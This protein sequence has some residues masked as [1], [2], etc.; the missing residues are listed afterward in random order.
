[1]KRILYIEDERV[2]ARTVQAQ[3][4][5]RGYQVDLVS[6]AEEG[7]EKLKQ[8]QYDL[9]LAD[10]NLPGMN[11]IELLQE[12]ALRNYSLP[13]IILTA[14]GDEKVAAEALKWGAADYV[15][16]EPTFLDHLPHTVEMTLSEHLALRQKEETEAALQQ[17]EA[18]YRALIEALP[19]I[20]LQVDL[21][22][23]I[24]Y[25]RTPEADRHL[26]KEAPAGVMFREC[27]SSDI[28]KQIEANFREALQYGR[29]R[30]FE[31]HFAHNQ[32]DHYY[33][34]HI[35]P[36][37]NDVIIIF[38]DI[39]TEKLAA[40]ERE[41]LIQ[42]LQEALSKIK[43]LSGLIPIC[44]SCRRIRDDRGYWDSLEEYL[45]KHSDAELSHSICPNC[46]KELYPEVYDPKKFGQTAA[47][48][49][50][51]GQTSPG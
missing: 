40:R 34:Y 18:H 1:M 38:R 32:V 25:S 22:G 17:S 6:S 15:I 10:Y 37:A 20:L 51:S 8:G 33:E 47:A 27:F 14:G 12:A 29:A 39:T 42:E 26:L 49:T 50:S 19:G 31:L 46:I 30:V 4:N 11:G 44:S 13:I 7:L 5:R 36:C 43:T 24:L 23:R 21:T 28:G 2:L 16:K 35:K 41:Q 45:H 9:L 3:L 48:P